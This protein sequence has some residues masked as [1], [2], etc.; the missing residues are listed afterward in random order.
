MGPLS[1]IR[2]IELGQLIA[3]PFCTRVLGEFGAEVIKV[4]SPNGGDPLRQWRKL[5][6]GTSLWWLLQARNKQSVTVNLK[7]PDGQEI[8]RRLVTQADILVENFRP[9]AM[10]KWGLGYDALS[11]ENPGL[12][13]VRLS[14]YGQSGPYRD[15]PGF[16]AIGEAMGG[17]RHVTGYPDRPPVRVGISLGDAVAALYGVIGALMALRQRDVNGGKGQ[18]VDVALY[19]AVFSLME[20]LLPEYDVYDFVRERSGASLP[21]IAPSNTYTT[22]DG[23]FVVIGA[24]GDSIFKRMMT[25]IGRDDLAND[26][27]LARNDGRAARSAE[28]DEAIG[29]WC[30]AR[31]LDEV[32]AVLDGAEVP[33]GKIYDIADI[34]KD[35]HFRAR[36]MI[37]EA[38]LSDGQTMK[39]PGV[40]P[41]LSA[42]PGG[43]RWLGPELGEHTASVLE[44]LGYDAQQIDDLRKRGV[45]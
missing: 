17:L 7:S 41:K 45:V 29:G 13:M 27:Q 42:T 37:E 39:I 20:S 1:G 5:Y 32:L 19:E 31:D 23:K 25:A 2:V 33:A 4:E 38:R 9:G 16:G 18:V 26:P 40:V 36:G 43:T 34:V 30:G 44:S 6:Q 8:V 15:K 12:V 35:V 21:G 11:R 22:R 3:G 28:L 24:N 10:E 14:G